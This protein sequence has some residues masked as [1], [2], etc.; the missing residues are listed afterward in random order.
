MV[1]LLLQQFQQQLYLLLLLL[2]L[3]VVFSQPAYMHGA[4]ICRSLP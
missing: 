2:L 4:F 1:Q 3:S